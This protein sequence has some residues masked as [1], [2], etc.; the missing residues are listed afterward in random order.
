M[1]NPIEILTKR[2]PPI[3]INIQMITKTVTVF[4]INFVAE[5]LESL[6][7][8]IV[9]SDEKVTVSGLSMPMT[10]DFKRNSDFKSALKRSNVILP[11]GMGIVWASRLICGKR[12]LKKRIAGPDFFYSFLHIA[13]L[14]GMR[15]FFLGSTDH[16]LSKIS[17][18]IRHDF[19]GIKLVGSY[20]PPFGEWSNEENDRIID[21]INRC[22]PDVLWVA[23]TAPKQDIWVD[24]NRKR[25]NVRI[26]VPVG[27][28]F[29]FF[30][31]TQDRA[32]MW[33]Q[34]MGLEWFHRTLKEP[35]RMGLRY[36]KGFPHFLL[37]LSKE[38]MFRERK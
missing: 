27:A 35:F 32:P 24:K 3:T 34:K 4:D 28:A 6:I 17:K 11:D 26:V 9:A 10:L 22:D 21:L 2:N 31:G 12:G 25:L 18:K 38:I 30:A 5:D 7:E 37:V 29:D 20:S 16:V 13:N 1:H 8:K 15:C 14:K 23:M 33:M 19:P 36:L